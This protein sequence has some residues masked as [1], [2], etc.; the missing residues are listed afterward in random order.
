VDACGSKVVC[1]CVCR[2]REREREREL[3]QHLEACR[4]EV[5]VDGTKGAAKCAGSTAGNGAVYAS[6][7]PAPYVSTAPIYVY[8]CMYVCTYIRIH[9]CMHVCMHACMYDC[10][11][12][13]AYRYIHTYIH[14]HLPHLPFPETNL[15]SFSSAKPCGCAIFFFLYARFVCDTWQWCLQKARAQAVSAPPKM[16]PRWH[17]RALHLRFAY[18]SI[19]Q[20]TSAY[21]SM[22]QHTQAYV[23][24]LRSR[25]QHFAPGVHHVN[26]ARLCVQRAAPGGGVRLPEARPSGA[27]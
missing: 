7:C 25:T 4:C 12:V 19:R 10:M 16:A 3:T 15:R 26:V 9:V 11:Y 17:P 13:Y 14:A 18:V 21:V 24:W 20:H 23:K 1:V 8:V 5:E 27:A 2:E 6:R 22:R